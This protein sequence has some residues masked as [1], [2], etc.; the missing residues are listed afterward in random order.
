MTETG[1]PKIEFEH[2]D[3][4]PGAIADEIMLD[5]RCRLLLNQFYSNLLESG[6]TPEDASK[7]AF[8]ADYYLR[9]Y[10]TDFAR[11]DVARPLPGIIRRFAAN[12]FITRT[13]DPDIALLERHLDA[14]RQFYR[15]L[16]QQNIISPDEFSFLEDEAGQTSYYK[17]RIDSFLSV[18]VDSYVAWDTECPLNS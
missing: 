12:W 9:D 13:L 7:L 15:F 10:L 4:T 14:I 6:C 1:L 11:Q 2:E 5:E 17:E 8:S 3:F 16:Q 18:T